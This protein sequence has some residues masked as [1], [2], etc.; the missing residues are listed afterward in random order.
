VTLYLD[1]SALVKLVVD[2]AETDPLRSFIGDRDIASA[3][4]ARTELLRAVSRRLPERLPAA[5]S[6]LDEVLLLLVDWDMA[7]VAA[8]L[9]PVE[10]RALD[11]LHV[12][13]ASRLEHGLD[14][15]VTY[16]RRMIQAAQT[17]GLPVASP[18]DAAE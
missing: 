8:E 15:L 3:M 9:Q 7:T 11:A 6:L 4:I 2:E 12:A 18:G 17:A 14:A 10:L 16:D 5:N 1:S 13:G